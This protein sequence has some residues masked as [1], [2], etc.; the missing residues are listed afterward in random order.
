MAK[1]FTFHCQ[2]KHTIWYDTTFTVQAES[3]EEAIKFLKE[4][5]EFNAD[6]LACTL[7]E[8]V[9]IVDGQYIYDSAEVME[10][11]DNGDQSTIEYMDYYDAD[12]VICSNVNE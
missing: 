9:N 5:N 3:K 4:H 1:N 8:K 12:K 11:S 7:P 2:Q 6:E 10:P